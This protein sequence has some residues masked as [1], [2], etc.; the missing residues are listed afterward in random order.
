[1]PADRKRPRVYVI[2]PVIGP[3]RAASEYERRAHIA[4]AEAIALAVARAG[5]FPRCPHTHTAHF[6]GVAGVDNAL[7]ME[8]G[9]DMLS[10]CDAAV[11]VPGWQR[12]LDPTIEVASHGSIAE[13]DWCAAHGLLVL[14]DQ[15][16][17]I[18]FVARWKH[19]HD[20][21][22]RLSPRPAPVPV[23]PR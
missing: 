4:R 7:W 9:L 16:E 14:R 18:A 17:V 3:F 6:D 11:L 5:A 23:L 21:G 22:E 15:A 10:E 2:G 19:D 13:R 1:M 8:L 20:C 12:Y